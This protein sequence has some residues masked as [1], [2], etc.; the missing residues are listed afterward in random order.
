MTDTFRLYNL[1]I[2]YIA[3]KNNRRQ[4]DKY[5]KKMNK[6]QSWH[7]KNL[8]YFYINLVM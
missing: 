7:M 3:V 2:P 5:E 1:L 6:E 4:D 8:T